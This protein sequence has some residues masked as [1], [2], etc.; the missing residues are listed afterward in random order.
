MGS[1]G[2]TVSERP[3]GDVIAAQKFLNANEAVEQVANGQGWPFSRTRMVPPSARGQG[4]G[5]TYT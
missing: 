2:Q 4:V 3:I 5:G 1:D